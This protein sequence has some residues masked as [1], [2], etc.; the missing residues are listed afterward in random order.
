VILFSFDVLAAPNK[1]LG[2]RQPI[3]EGRRLWNSFVTT[4]NGRIAVLGTGIANTPVFIEW[5]KREGFKASTID[6]IEG[7]DSQSKIDR[8]L[9]LNAVYG[10]I[11]WYIDA[12]P[13]AVAGV[14]RSGISTLLVTIPH[15]V[16][17]EWDTKRQVKGW[18]TLVQE[19][20]SQTLA[21]AE[22][23]WSDPR[24]VI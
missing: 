3:P 15:T 7:T 6:I 8:V 4:Y 22:K 9:S 10:K 17:P 2:A 18:D 12:D 21:R 5:L 24:D 23:N 16:R 14:V 11:D 19:I 20:E 13:E 1:E